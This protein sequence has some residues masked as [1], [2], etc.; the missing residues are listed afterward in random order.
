MTDPFTLVFAFYDSAGNPHNLETNSTFTAQSDWSYFEAFVDT[1]TGDAS[2]KVDGVQEASLSN[3]DSYSWSP[4]SV[5]L[6][7]GANHNNQ[8]SGIFLMDDLQIFGIPEPASCVLL[9]VAC[10]GLLRRRR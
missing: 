5:P 8:L 10:V 3:L 9:L 6:R 7:L 4:R 2:L 1:L